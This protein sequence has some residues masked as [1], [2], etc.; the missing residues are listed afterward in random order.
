MKQFKNKNWKF[1]FIFIIILLGFSIINYIN[2]SGNVIN[3]I[4]YKDNHFDDIYGNV[5]DGYNDS[6]V[7]IYGGLHNV[8][9]YR[10]YYYDVNFDKE[11]MN[12]NNYLEVDENNIDEIKKLFNE[13]KKQFSYGNKCYSQYNK[14]NINVITLGDY[15]SIKR[16]DKYYESL[17]TG[18]KEQGYCPGE[19]YFIVYLYDIDSHNLYYIREA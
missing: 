6:V 7:C 10:I 12:N 2:D 9:E 14:F 3:S 16:T 1:L 17:K 4:Y 15:F 11:Y 18:C 8:S 5:L 13:M 19:A